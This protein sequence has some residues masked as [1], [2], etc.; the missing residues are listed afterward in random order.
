MCKQGHQ[1]LA[2][3]RQSWLCLTWCG[4]AGPAV[5]ARRGGLQQDTH[6]PAHRV[7]R[8]SHTDVLHVV[9]R[10]LPGQPQRKR[11]WCRAVHAK[12]FTPAAFRNVLL[13][14]ARVCQASHSPFSPLS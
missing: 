14:Q 10:A 2:V 3:A 9:D 8:Q 11:V 4:A 1:K 6:V 12:T 13:M 7:H 5:A